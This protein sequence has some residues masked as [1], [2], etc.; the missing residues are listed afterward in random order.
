M[1]I[2]IGAHTGAHGQNTFSTGTI[3]TTGASLLVL[4]LGYLDSSGPVISDSKSNTWTALTENTI[5][6]NTAQRM[7]YV[8]NPIVGTGHTF[9]A[10]GSNIQAALSVCAVN[11]TLTASVLDQTAYSGPTSAA[12]INAGSV[13]PGTANQVIFSG[14]GVGNVLVTLSID[15]GYTITDTIGVGSFDWIGSLAYKIQTTALATDP[16]WTSDAT[17]YMAATNATFKSAAGA[18]NQTMSAFDD[19]NDSPLFITGGG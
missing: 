18:L 1:A 5:T 9:T 7:F 14:L 16:T 10:T 6:G 17:S 15:S 12:T 3:D 2:T 19:I 11:G 8:Q 13:T 4:N